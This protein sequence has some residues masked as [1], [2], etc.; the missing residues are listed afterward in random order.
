MQIHICKNKEG[1]ECTPLHLWVAA[2]GSEQDKLTHADPRPKNI[3]KQQLIDRY[4]LENN[5]H[6]IEEYKDGVL[7][8]VVLLDD[9]KKNTDENQKIIVYKN[10]DGEIC[11]PFN[12]WVNEFGSEEEKIIH[13]YSD[14]TQEKIQLTQKY[15]LAVN[16]VIAQI[17]VQDNLVEEIDLE[18]EGVLDVD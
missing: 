8:N 3:E 5:V 17:Y 14:D 6:S 2:T 12:E 15:M 11:Q 1:L 9:I 13:D 10:K 18:D 7:L 4:Y 16:A